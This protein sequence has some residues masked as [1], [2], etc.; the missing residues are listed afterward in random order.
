MHQLNL[1]IP[2]V[3]PMPPRVEMTDEQ[4][5]KAKA[6]KKAKR[7]FLNVKTD[8]EKRVKYVLEKLLGA[9]LR[10]DGDWA[11]LP[12]GQQI[13]QRKV[14]DFSGGV[15]LSPGAP[16]SSVFVEVKGCA[17][18]SDFSLARLDRPQRKGAPSQSQRL[19]EKHE[20]GYLVWLAIGWWYALKSATKPIIEERKGRTYTKWEKDSVGLEIDLVPWDIWE[21]RILPAL[22]R[23]KTAQRTLRRRDRDLTG[24]CRIYKVKKWELAPTHWFKYSAEDI[25]IGFWI[26][27]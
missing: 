27:P 24:D 11:T 19:S 16:R 2:G 9:D 22:A 14:S 5:A 12:G 4:K 20:E 10:K 18:G 21:V 23:R 13:W 3:D 1:P 15:C 17:P 25:S 8:T 7:Q 26:L 6:D